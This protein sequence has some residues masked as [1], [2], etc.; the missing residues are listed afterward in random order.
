MN[1]NIIFCNKCGKIL[2]T[3]LP[4]CKYCGE[5][6]LRYKGT[7]KIEINSNIK[8][9]IFTKIKQ[10]FSTLSLILMIVINII[11]FITLCILNTNINTSLTNNIIAYIIIA[12][13]YFYFICFELIFLKAN[14]PWY[15]IFIP[16]Y[17]FYA[18]FELC[19]KKGL[20]CFL[21]IIPY[22]FFLIGNISYNII[23]I[24]FSISLLIALNKILMFFL[25]K[26]F[27]I[28]ELFG[29]LLFPI[30]I[31]LIAFNNKYTYNE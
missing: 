14:Y 31:P 4:N 21:L 6:N 13:L 22:I 25:A 26:R 29:M 9:D 30:M 17:N 7:R 8:L 24:T 28:H 10:K 19:T 1:N 5:V 20:L 18:Y 11:L 2:D 27:K 16:L 23:F 12:I 15:V 3:N